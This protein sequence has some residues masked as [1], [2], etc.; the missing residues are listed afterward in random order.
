MKEIIDEMNEEKEPCEYCQN[1]CK[2]ILET[3]TY[4]TEYYWEEV[5]K[6]RYYSITLG[7]FIDKGHLRLVD[8]DQTNCLDSG[9]SIKINFCPFC[10]NKIEES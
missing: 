4:N 9:E 5:T 7:V 2:P 8:V 6:L 10:G 3:E 1:R